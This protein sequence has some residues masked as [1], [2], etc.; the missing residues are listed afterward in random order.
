M[1]SSWKLASILKIWCNLTSKNLIEQK[2]WFHKTNT[3]ET[4]FPMH[5]TE[6]KSKVIFEINNSDTA[7]QT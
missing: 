4:S 3:D 7:A 2:K 1:T 6:Q 5:N